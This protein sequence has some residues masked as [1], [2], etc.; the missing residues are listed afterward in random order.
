[1]EKRPKYIKAMVA[2]AQ[3]HFFDLDGY[4]AVGMA[5]RVIIPLTQENTVSM[6]YGSEYMFLPDRR[7]VVYNIALDTLEILAENPY[8]RGEPV[9]P[10]AA[11]NAPGFTL[12]LLSAYRETH[13]A[14]PLPLFSYGAVGWSGKGPRVA[15]LR[16]DRERRQDLRLMP[17]EKVTEGVKK[18]RTT[19]PKNRL[20]RHLETCALEYGCPAAKNFFLGRYEAPLPTSIRCN[21]Q[22]WGCLS[23]QKSS[24]ISCT[25]ERISF[26]PS[27]EEIQ[28]IA[29]F[30][31]KRTRRSV[32][33]F[34]QGCEGEPLLAM[35][36]IEP[37]I[38]LIRNETKGGTINLNTNGSRPDFV[39]RL[40]DA[41]LDSMRV[42]MNSANKA[43]YEAYFQ[44]KGYGF[45]DVTQS[46]DVAVKKGHFVSINYLSIPGFTDHPDEVEALMS[47]LQN[48]PV[49]MIQWR[50]LNFDPVR[51]WR[52][53]GKT[54][55]AFQPGIG[56]VGL[57]EK[58]QKAFPNIR[59]GYFNPPKETFFGE[60]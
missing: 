25:Q 15:A 6:P 21:A 35:D 5:H 2:D 8:D 33:S 20:C 41:G 24:D 43:C 40:F 44:P 12:S 52:D 38:R 56:M 42:S 4:A 59:F 58:V 13:R 9:F 55:M 32:V 19:M 11:F 57:L 28:E 22:C 34:G 23:L 14:A 17:L 49:S 51:Y 16:V 7:P 29:V 10:V 27:P 1:M 50:N 54:G 48:H 46:I 3:G 60:R 26:T 37:A 39:A 31:M 36:A 47:F 18:L 30:H 53:V 45:D